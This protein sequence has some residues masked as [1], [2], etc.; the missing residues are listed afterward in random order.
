MAL[1]KF[2][3]M[4]LMSYVTEFITFAVVQ[5]KEARAEEWLQM[6]RTRQDECVAT[7]DREHMHFESIFRHEAGG[8][9]YLSWLSVQ[10]E[11][12]EHVASSAFEIDQAH[13]AFWHECIDSSVAPVKHAH[14][15]DF[16]AP[17][18]A[19]AIAAREQR[20][21]MSARHG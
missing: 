21:A 8:R 19:A 6:L 10:G 7:L 20:L 2:Q 16:V 13:M 5:G 17:D 3:R 4:P 12:G 11:H 9:M 1:P 14:V 18:V 15:V